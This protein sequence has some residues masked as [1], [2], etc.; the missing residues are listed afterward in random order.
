MTKQNDI[1]KAVIRN[2][3]GLRILVFDELHTHHGRQG[4]SR[5]V[6][7]KGGEVPFQFIVTMT[8]APHPALLGERVA[9]LALEHGVEETRLLLQELQSLLLVL[10]DAYNCTVCF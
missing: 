4:C 8:S 2:G 5:D 1:D 10:N 7:W 3:K 6:S 9:A